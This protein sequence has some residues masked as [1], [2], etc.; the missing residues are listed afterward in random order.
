VSRALAG[1]GWTDTLDYSERGTDVAV[2]L[3]AGTATGVGLQVLG[4]TNA[5][6][7]SGN[8]R[9]LGNDLNNLL[10]GGGGDDALNGGAGRDLLVGGSGVDALA[11]G[12]GAGEDLLVGGAIVYYLEAPGAVDLTALYAV[13]AEWARTDLAYADRVA[14]L[15]GTDSGGF[16]Y[17][18]NATT[19]TDDAA[20]DTLSGG[21]GADWFVASVSGLVPDVL[22]DRLASETVTD[23]P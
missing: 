16:E 11:G 22:N 10:A 12:T 15:G 3:A 20:T 19:V 2:D 4:I 8:D 9:L 1:N 23:I 14:R 18:I 21:S 5:V 13:R 7:G 6:G 17:V